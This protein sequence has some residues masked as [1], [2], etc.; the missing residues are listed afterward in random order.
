MRPV[1][2]RMNNLLRR[3]LYGARDISPEVEAAGRAGVTYQAPGTVLHHGSPWDQLPVKGKIDI[4]APKDH[5]VTAL[6]DKGSF[7]KIFQDVENT[8]GMGAV[9]PSTVPLADMK[10]GVKGDYEYMRRYLKDTMSADGWIIKPTDESLGSLEGFINQNTN[11]HSAQVQQAWDK[12]KNYI[13][14]EKL[15]FD[16][17]YRVHTMQGVPFASTHRRAPPGKFR[18]AWN[19]ISKSMGIGEGGFA[20]VPVQGEEAQRLHDFISKVN[21]PLHFNYG[22][23]PVHQAFDVGRMPDGSFRLIESNPTPGTFNNPGISRKLQEAVTGRMHPDKALAGAA[24]IGAGGGAAGYGVGTG[25]DAA[26]QEKR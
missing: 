6:A 7:A 4:N 25:I 2:G 22:Q 13:L 5:L 18:D 3:I 19:R 17:E 16:A 1:E 14:Q 23:A 12:P 10:A 26:T 9:I 24:L 15:P 11:P 21:E 8:P 20:H